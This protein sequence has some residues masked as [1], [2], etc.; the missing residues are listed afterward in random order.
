[1]MV[2]TIWAACICFMLAGSFFYIYD[3]SF[4][5]GTILAFILGPG[6]VLHFLQSKRTLK[7]DIVQFSLLGL[8]FGLASFATLLVPEENNFQYL[9]AFAFNL[10]AFPIVAFLCK[11]RT[12]ASKSGLILF[13]IIILAIAILQI[14]YLFNGIGIDPTR[15]QAADYA[16][17]DAFAFSGVR[18]IF[19]NPNDFSVICVLLIIITLYGIRISERVRAVIVVILTLMILMAASRTNLVAAILVLSSY[20]LFS[21]KRWRELLHYGGIGIIVFSLF[22]LSDKNL[23]ES[24]WARRAETIFT[25]ASLISDSS[26]DRRTNQYLNFIEN[27]DLI[28]MGSFRAQNYNYFVKNDDLFSR[29]P[30]SLIIELALLFGYVGLFIGCVV[31]YWLFTCFRLGGIGAARSL[32]LLVCVVMVTFVSSS[33]INFPA[34]W[35]LIYFIGIGSRVSNSKNE[36]FADLANAPSPHKLTAIRG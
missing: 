5:I 17:A 32:L 26:V 28:A 27:L 13:F 22:S 30:H 11:N 8:L 19:G 4:A 9:K 31:F 23:S 24:Y 2:N 21:S 35:V 15:E 20:Y 16:I 33:V 36:Y 1:M 34:F 7:L 10:A 14:S 18:S 3:H 12:E 6:F 25:T 29:N